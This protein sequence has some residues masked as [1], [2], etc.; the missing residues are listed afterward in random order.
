MTNSKI[1]FLSGTR[2]VRKDEDLPL[3][4]KLSLTVNNTG[5][6]FF[7]QAVI[8]QLQNI[9]IIHSW[10]AAAQNYNTLVLSMA[11]FISPSVDFTYA[12]N[13]LEKSKIEKVIM[14]GAGAQAYDFG[15]Q[16]EIKD[17]TRRFI[18]ILSERSAA[19]GVRGYYTAEL[20]N[21]MGIKN[22]EVI[23]CP[24]MFW[25]L[26]RNFN[27]HP[28]ALPQLPKIAIHATPSG[29]FRDKVSN[30]FS[31]GM[32]HAQAYIAQNEKNLILLSM[33][34]EGEPPNADFMFNYYN[35]GTASPSDLKDWFTKNTKCFFDLSEWMNY[36]KSFDFVI[37]S[38]FHGN[39][40][41]I[42]MGV[43]ALSLIFDTRTRELCEFLNLPYCFLQDLPEKAAPE[44]LYE[45]TDYSIFNK[46]FKNKF[47]NY[48]TFLETND[49][50]HNL[51]TTRAGYR[52][53][54]NTNGRNLNQYDTVK[55]LSTWVLSC[56]IAD[57]TVPPETV[58]REIFNRMRD[59]RPAAVRLLAER[60][61]ME[62]F[63]KTEDAICERLRSL[64]S[65]RIETLNRLNACD[66]QLQAIRKIV[67]F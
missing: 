34:Q 53:K 49:L 12:A 32:K 66:K 45:L 61:Q 18:N 37:G 20:L 35:D 5:N 38:R 43:P 14:I 19:I 3:D 56:D 21:R 17:G 8:R 67:Q 52:Y 4:K 15:E 47:D 16:I 30:L 36:L 60:G 23:G 51:V 7:E 9:D 25:H 54:R 57:E 6:Y 1:A 24:S 26:D 48:I 28:P 13:M 33:Q 40:A 29:Y 62:S 39:M 2:E 42:Q 10:Q 27:I 59:E 65:V 44:Q 63:N 55:T 22:V 58:L 64:D 46:T 11:N 50:E 41:A 31:F